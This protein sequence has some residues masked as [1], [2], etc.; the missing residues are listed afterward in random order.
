MEIDKFKPAKKQVFLLL[1]VLLFGFILI[2]TFLL[3]ATGRSVKEINPNNYEIKVPDKFN[4]SCT[5]TQSPGAYAFRG[6]AFIEGERVLDYENHVVLY[7]DKSNKYYKIP[8]DMQLNDDAINAFNDGVNY[9]FAGFTAF[10]IEKQ[11]K[12]P[13]EEYEI[14][15][16]YRN[17]DYNLLIPTGQ[18]MVNMK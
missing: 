14:Y 13:I 3:R 11:L 15:F 18:T 2:F 1:V 10:V 8:T 5:V 12:H 16:A 17:N 4:Y 9:S 7:H 6:W